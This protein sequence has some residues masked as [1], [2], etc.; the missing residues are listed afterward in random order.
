MGWRYLHF[1]AGGLVLVMATLRLLVLKMQQTPKWLIS[2]NRDGEAYNIIMSISRKY[3]RPL[4]LSLET[5][6]SQ[7]RVLHTEKSVWSALRLRKH[8]AGLFETKLLAYSTVM[9]IAN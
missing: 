6:Q 3:N 9:I 8:F 4:G 7:G 1:T 2:Q 5:L